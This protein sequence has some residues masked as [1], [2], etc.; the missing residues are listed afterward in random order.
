MNL[1]PMPAMPERYED[2]DYIAWQKDWKHAIPGVPDTTNDYTE[3]QMSE[4][5]ARAYFG[6]DESE[7]DMTVITEKLNLILE[8]QGIII[9]MLDGA[10]PPVEPPVVPPVVPPPAASYWVRV[11]VPKANARF[12]KS[13]NANGLPIMQIYPSDSSL[14][15]ERIQFAE[16][17]LLK[18]SPDKVRADGGGYYYLL[19]DWEGR[20]DEDL[21]LRGQDCVKTW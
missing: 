9:A 6:V 10:E 17:T 3:V 20:D 2:D 8:N 7:D 11:T 16:N 12:A 5:E 19:L 18:V 1:N 21:Y 15:S 4:Q 14:V 13:H